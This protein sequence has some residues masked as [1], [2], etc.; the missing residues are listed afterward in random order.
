VRLQ[1]PAPVDTAPGASN[2]RAVALRG[3]IGVGKTEAARRILELTG[4][5]PEGLIDLDQGWARGERR[6]AGGQARYEDLRGRPEPV[7]VLE[8]VWGEPIGEGFPGATRNPSEWADILTDEGRELRLFR[9]TAR[10]AVII[11]RARVRFAERG[12][13]PTARDAKHW[14]GMYNRHPDVIGLPE[15]LGIAEVF[16]DTTALMPDQVA[17]VILAKFRGRFGR[18]ASASE[19]VKLADR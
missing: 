14:I 2:P 6:Y 4:S 17:E 10:P 8:L 12:K 9:L 3:P 19:T 13:G 16:V 11:R 7:I 15:R 5:S 18:G 1:L